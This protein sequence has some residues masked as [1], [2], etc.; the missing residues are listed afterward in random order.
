MC[1]IIIFSITGSTKSHQTTKETNQIKDYI[2][3]SNMLEANIDYRGCVNIEKVVTNNKEEKKILSSMD[4]N[5][6]EGQLTAILGP[7]GQKILQMT[8]LPFFFFL[9]LTLLILQMKNCLLF[10]FSENVQ[11]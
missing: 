1:G 6:P 8:W 7:S 3:K 10:F 5:F 2:I 4:I 11:I 9:K